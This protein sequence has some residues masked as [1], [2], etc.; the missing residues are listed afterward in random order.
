M[1][2]FLVDADAA[3]GMRTKNTHDVALQDFRYAQPLIK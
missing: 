1:P 2:H 3:L